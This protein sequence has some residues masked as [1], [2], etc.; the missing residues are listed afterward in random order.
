MREYEL[1]KEYYGSK[2]AKRSGLP[3][4]NH[5]DEGI[6]ILERLE[7]STTAIQAFCLHPIIQDASSPLNKAMEI[8]ELADSSAIVLALEYAITANQYLP[9]HC[10]STQ[11]LLPYI[12][13]LEVKQMLIADKVQNFKDFYRTFSTRQYE[14]N[15]QK[16]KMYF[17]NWLLYLKVYPVGYNSLI[18][19]LPQWSTIIEFY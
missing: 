16:L 6:R 11:D 12:P 2:V 19:G 9:K 4:I 10:K 17:S 8:E 1:I 15:Y 18:K 14:C 7:A 13:N 3:L 5:I